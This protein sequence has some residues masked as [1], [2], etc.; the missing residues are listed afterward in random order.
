MIAI[1]IFYPKDEKRTIVFL[2][3]AIYR[4]IYLN[5]ANGDCTQNIDIV[6]GDSL[7]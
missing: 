2:S 6:Y 4:T 1:K 5:G 3:T 7:H